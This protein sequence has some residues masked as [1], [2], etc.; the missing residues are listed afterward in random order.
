MQRAG[1]SDEG[2]KGAVEV[3]VTEVFGETERSLAKV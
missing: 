2:L 3:L 1:D